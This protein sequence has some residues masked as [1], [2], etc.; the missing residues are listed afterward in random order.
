MMPGYA[1]R[2]PARNAARSTPISVATSSSRGWRGRAAGGSGGT[3]VLIA[4]VTE[5]RGVFLYGFANNER[6][7]IDS[8]ELEDLKKLARHYLGYTDTQIGMALQEKELTEVTCD[9]QE[10]A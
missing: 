4:Y 5:Q 9:D 7:N 1:K 6:D 8:R 2:S 10:E 3:R